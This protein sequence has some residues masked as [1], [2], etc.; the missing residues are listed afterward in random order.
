MSMSFPC[1]TRHSHACAAHPALAQVI[2]CWV[3][4]DKARRAHPEA[5]RL[6][7]KIPSQSKAGILTQVGI[8]RGRAKRG[9]GGAL[10]GRLSGEGDSFFDRLDSFEPFI[11]ACTAT[12]HCP[13]P[14]WLVV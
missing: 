8:S 5:E 14:L 12:A 9:G 6:R 1:T 3:L 13:P 4:A 10:A 7:E 11:H 2:C